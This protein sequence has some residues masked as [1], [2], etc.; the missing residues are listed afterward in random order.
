MRIY[1][2]CWLAD[3]L[4]YADIFPKVRAQIDARINAGI[5]R[6]GR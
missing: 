3:W 2:L 4:E 5:R 6:S 1:L